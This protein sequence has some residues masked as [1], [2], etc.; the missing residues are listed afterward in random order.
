MRRLILGHYGSLGPEGQEEAITTLTSRPDYARELLEAV[1]RGSLDR[2]VITA[3][4]ARQ[5]RSFNDEAI[6]RELSRLWGA[7]R[8][9]TSEKQQTIA[10]LKGKLSAE[11]L[12]TA[13]LSS[14][15]AMFEKTCAS[16]H[17]LYGHGGS[18]GPDLT[19][20][21][22]H[23]LDYLLE[24]IVDPSATLVI[25]FKMSVVVTK[26]GRVVTGVVVEETDHTV[27]VRTQTERV[28]L[29]RAEISRV[30]PQNASL[31]PEG[32]L[33]P[34]SGAQVRDLFAYLSGREQVPLPEEGS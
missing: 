5:M 4:H 14:G 11:R 6:T 30:V 19:G 15:R 27:A 32:L 1:H 2:N 34:L 22:R 7:V 20:S 31:M 26:D 9:T 17:A 23:N 33:T 13:D 16:C 10:E 21:N 28:V 18:I 24:N 25:D 8:A 3:Y 29:N 12:K